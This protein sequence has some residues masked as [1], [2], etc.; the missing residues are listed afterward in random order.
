MNRDEA[1]LQAKSSFASGS[2]DEALRICDRLLAAN[3]SDAEVRYFRGRC[4]AARGEWREAAADFQ[5]VLALLPKF[6]P[7]MLALGI[8]RQSAGEPAAAREILEQARALDARPAEVHF[9]LG[10]AA[11]QA[12][13]LPEA[14]DAFLAT[15]TR[16]PHLP[17]AHN[18][19]GVAL[20]R[21]GAL[22]EAAASFRLAIH[23]RPG[24]VAAHTNLGDVLLRTGQ[25]AAAALAFQA[26]SA[27]DP[28]APVLAQLGAARLLA[29]DFTGAIN[30]FER[31]LALDA[32]QVDGTAN[33]AEALR[34]LG[35][36][37]R[38]E[39]EFRRALALD[40]RAS[41]AHLGLGKVLAA[42]GNISEAVASLIDAA[43]LS[44]GDPRLIMTI[45]SVLDALERREVAID[46]LE[47]ACARV[48]GD[49]PLLEALAIELH[50][51][52]RL[53][54]A[55]PWYERALAIEP[56]RHQTLL[57]VGRALENLGRYREALGYLE[58]AQAL[59][60]A[61]P[62]A[63]AA[64]ASCAARVCAWDTLERCVAAL[65]ALPDG[66]A[67]L[68]S[69]VLFA[70][71][72]DPQEQAHAL[73]R[74]GASIADRSLVSA[75][76]PLRFDHDRL[77]IA[78]LSPDFRDHPVAHALAGVIAHH[79][80]RRFRTIGVSLAP[81]DAS[82][83]GARIRE[84]FEECVD[85][86]AL[87]APALIELLRGLEIDIAIDLAGHTAGARPEL[88]AARVAAMQVAY[89]GFPGSTGEESMDFIV[90]DPT[91]IRSEDEKLYSERVLRMPGCYLPFDRDAARADAGV[92]RAQA[93]LPE[94]GFVFCAFHSAYKVTR[95]MMQL[96]M[97]L[98]REIP[99]SV[100]WLRDGHELMRTNLSQAAA[101]IGIAEQR[102]IF[103]PFVTDKPSYY[104][105]LRC[106]DLFLD[107]LPYNAHTTACE[108][109]W[110]G[111][112]VLTCLGRHFA[113][114][115]AASVLET[116]GR[117]DL[118]CGSLEQYLDRALELA[119]SPGALGELR[120]DL[121][122]SRQTSRLFDT[123]RYTRDFE[124]LLL[125]GWQQTSGR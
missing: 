18:N 108:A 114:R 76:L 64:L 16:N 95:K 51:A 24:F 85:A 40:P 69:L 39:Q 97:Q 6:Q 5:R 1:L 91:V 101:T 75:K 22:P 44:P 86:S 113:G 31:S 20:D 17:E 88:F 74:R 110:A 26:A 3:A 43:R 116:A 23:H 33:L 96:W 46:L 66:L 100:L 2:I 58:H 99:G 78:Y 45:S 98:L 109:L 94:E 4:R 30:A 14:I 122:R 83:I 115:V 34:N 87:G 80:R 72:V 15:L 81:A 13:A 41:A 49:A 107:A 82:A 9:A 124:A 19:L 38:A 68:Q 104:A 62:E 53:A 65:R 79:D 73:R 11:L 7:A 63:V 90:A 59:R 56:Q 29:G 67:A 121:A 50:R 25:P 32:H 120:A 112:P 111:V 55:V 84:S 93:G 12:G 118:V 37:E 27:L 60:G 123:A 102:L 117:A 21:S 57:S 103:A 8:A 48:P 35:Q 42:Q 36:L 92:T 89:L 71:D 119:R 54:D 52:G 10:N 47:Q 105:R 125:E 106:A 70:A 61:D 28:S 77:R